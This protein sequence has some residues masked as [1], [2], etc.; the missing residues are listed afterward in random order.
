MP[1][2]IKITTKRII[3]DVKNQRHYEL[4]LKDFTGKKYSLRIQLTEEDEVY[5]DKNNK[6]SENFVEQINN[7]LNK[8][9][10]QLIKKYKLQETN[11]NK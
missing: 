6:L 9:Q 7:E 11:E 5:I 2:L 8:L 3:R 10:E 1:A 4:L